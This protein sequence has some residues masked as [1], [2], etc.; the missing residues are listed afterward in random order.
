MTV[1]DVDE[2]S[3]ERAGPRP[4]RHR[5]RSSSTSGPSGA[6]RAARSPRCSSRRR[7]H[8]RARSCWPRSTPTRTPACRPSFGIQGIPAVKAFRDGGVVERVRRSAAAFG[9][10]AVLRRPRAERGRRARRRR[11]TRPR[12]GACWSS[13]RAAPTLPWRSR[14]SCTR[15][16]T[17]TAR[18]SCSR[19]SPASFQADGLAARITLERADDIDVSAALRAARRGRHRDGRRRADRGARGPATT[20]RSCGASSIALL[21]QLGVEH[22]VAREG[23]RRLAAA[24]Y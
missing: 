14:P 23:R 12:S 9:R 2:A 1:I 16:A 10:R 8:A 20:A 4:L 21:D 7:R 13:S 19:T 24:L 11:A 5:S 22:P 3:F 18:W 6:G 15:A 17:P